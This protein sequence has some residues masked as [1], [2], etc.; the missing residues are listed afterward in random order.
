MIDIYVGKDKKQ[1]LFRV[2]QK[3]LCD[4]VPYFRGMVEGGFKEAIEGK[5]T[6]EE[7]NPDSF[8][9]LLL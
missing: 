5:T 6:L 3:L 2:H 1:R 7:D 8:D 9:L 4:N